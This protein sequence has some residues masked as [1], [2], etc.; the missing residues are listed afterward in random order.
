MTRKASTVFE[1][2][3]SM[4]REMLVVCRR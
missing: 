2:F 4:S 1:K 3:L